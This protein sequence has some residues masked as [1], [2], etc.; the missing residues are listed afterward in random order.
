MNTLNE[1]CSD[2]PRQL[3]CKLP[4]DLYLASLKKFITEYEKEIKLLKTGIGEQ[5]DTAHMAQPS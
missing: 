4:A 5:P 1:H 3:Y 2:Y